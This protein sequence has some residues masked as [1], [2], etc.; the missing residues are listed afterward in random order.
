MRKVPTLRGKTVI[1]CFYEASTRTRTSFE[2]AGKRLSADVVNIGGSSSSTSKGETPAR[3]GDDARRDARRR[4]RAPARRVRGASLR[5]RARTRRDR[6]RRRR[7]A[8]AP[9]SSPARRVHDPEAARQRPARRSGR[10]L[11]GHRAQPRGA[12]ERARCS[13][14]SA[15]RFGFRGR[16]RSCRTETRAWVAR[17]TSGSNPR[18]RV[19]TW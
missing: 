13:R 8:R 11:R 12:F 9:H 1:N 17:R 3:H 2:L 19:R 6:E 5:R 14:S 7:H 18:S 15:P 16:A 10:Y 4:D